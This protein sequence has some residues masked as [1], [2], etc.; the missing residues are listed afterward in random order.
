MIAS[1]TI[2]MMQRINDLNDITIRTMEEKMRRIHISSIVNYCF[3]V[4]K[5]LGEGF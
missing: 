3:E 5:E 2:Y 1:G 4:L